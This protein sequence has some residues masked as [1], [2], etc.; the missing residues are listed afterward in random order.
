MRRALRQAV[1]A[2]G[3][4][5]AGKGVAALVVLAAVVFAWLAPQL[6]A[7]EVGQGAG[8]G[9]PTATAVDRSSVSDAARAAAARDA[10]RAT[11]VQRAHLDPATFEQVSVHHVVDGDTVSVEM[12]DGERASVRLIGID[13]PES[14]APQPERNSEEGVMASD[15]LKSMVGEGDTLWLQYDTTEADKYGRPL[16]YVWLEH[17]ANAEEAADPAFVAQHMLNAIQ[18]IDGYGQAKTYRPDTLHD[19]LFA[20]W[21]EEALA[22]ARGVTRTWA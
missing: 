11:D 7:L 4:S 21:G 5:S 12:P 6:T 20:Q 17:P 19:D 22:D 9:S 1:K 3:K 16:A 15:H 18:V 14:V 13:T 8:G 2:L 10:A